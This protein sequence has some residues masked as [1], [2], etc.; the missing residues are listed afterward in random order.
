[1]ERPQRG[2]RPQAGDAKGVEEKVGGPR[3]PRQ[4]ITP[5]NHLDHTMEVGLS[6]AIRRTHEGGGHSTLPDAHRGNRAKRLASGDTSSWKGGGMR[7]RLVPT[8]GET[9]H[10]PLPKTNGA[11]PPRTMRNRT[12]GRDTLNTKVCAACGSLA[13]SVWRP[14]T[15]SGSE[16]N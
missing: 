2:K 1:M 16:G 14:R 10:P 15:V 12:A 7:V 11:N 9:H 13:S 8:N 5:P 6:Q 3:R 4:P